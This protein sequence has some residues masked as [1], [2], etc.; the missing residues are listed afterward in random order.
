[1]YKAFTLPLKSAFALATL[2]ILTACNGFTIDLNSY[3]QDSECSANPFLT[4]CDSQRNI[5]D[6]RTLIIENCASNPEKSETTLCLAADAA[7]NTSDTTESCEDNPFGDG[8]GGTGEVADVRD[9]EGVGVYLGTTPKDEL[10]KSEFNKGDGKI[11]IASVEIVDLCSDPTT[12]DNERCTPAVL[13]CINNPFSGSCQGDNVLGNLIKGGVTLSKTVIL[14]NKRAVD[15]RDGLIGRSQCQNLNVQ[16][17]RCAGAAFSTDSICSAVTHSVCKADAFDPLCGE[18]ENFAG[19]YFNER[20][21]VCF[22]DP[23]NPNCTGANGHIAVVCSEYPFDRLCDGNANYENVRANACDANPNVSPNCPVVV[24]VVPTTTGDRV[25]AAD[26]VA[27]FNGTLRSQPDADN[28][29]SSFLEGTAD[30]LNSGTLTTS[31]STTSPK[32]RIYNVNFDTA[33]F[34]GKLLNGDV[35]DGVAYFKGAYRYYA[36]VLS[37]TD[38]GAPI[39]RTGKATWHGSINETDWY[40]Y[41]TDF[42]LDIEF[43]GATGGTIKGFTQSPSYSYKHEIHHLLITGVFD[44]NGVI[45]GI[46]N[47]GFFTNGNPDLPI[48]GKDTGRRVIGVLKGLIGEEGAVGAFVAKDATYIGYAGGFVVRPSEAFESPTP[49]VNNA[50]VTAADWQESFDEGLL[51]VPNPV[52]PDPGVQG[53]IYPIVNKFLKGSKTGLSVQNRE[54]AWYEVVTFADVT[55]G[56]DAAYGF[57]LSSGNSGPH[58]AGILS[59]TDLGLPLTQTQGSVV[60]DGKLKILS[61]SRRS[62]DTNFSLHISF[63]AGSQAG[64]ITGQVGANPGRADY[65]YK[66]DGEFDAAGVITGT[67]EYGNFNYEDTKIPRYWRSTGTLTGLIGQEGAIGVFISNDSGY[68]GYTGGFVARPPSQ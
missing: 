64:T 26:W 38:L 62:V 17:Q 23:N 34:D 15:C 53:S 9:I 44:S 61:S 41:N 22:E 37:T 65:K 48:Y 7:T 36:G 16:K 20:S 30:G 40:Y 25:T 27:S 5:S 2:F 10:A 14:Q 47:K 33:S 35:E 46:S 58:Y 8:C 39:N 21:H 59:G 11:T 18:K 42:S 6:I 1:M 63:G 43:N 57:A 45:T 3:L 55:L 66:L 19:V 52:V 13:D 12:A 54:R 29:E 51:S 32:P 28:L 24:P 4:E 56:G 68:G 49:L 31:L 67:S 60:W 50:R